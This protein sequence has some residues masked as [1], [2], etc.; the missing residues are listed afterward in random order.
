MAAEI[1]KSAQLRRFTINH[2]YL[3]NTKELFCNYRLQS[4]RNKT[5]RQPAPHRAVWNAHLFD[6]QYLQWRAR[7]N[8]RAAFTVLNRFSAM[9]AVC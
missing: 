1:R 2:P 9:A 4:Q 3:L 5:E 6:Q 7:R 8:K